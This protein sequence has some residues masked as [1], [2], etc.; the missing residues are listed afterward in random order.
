MSENKIFRKLAT[1]I[2]NMSTH[3]IDRVQLYEIVCQCILEATENDKASVN[4]QPVVGDNDYVF[5]R[6]WLQEK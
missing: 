4:K 6:R 5:S 1:A 3:K 2:H